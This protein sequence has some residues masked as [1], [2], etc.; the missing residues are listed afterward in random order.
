PRPQGGGAGVLASERALHHAR[1]GRLPLSRRPRAHRGVAGKVR[2]RSA[3]ARGGT[4][5]AGAGVRLRVHF[6]HGGAPGASRAPD[7]GRARAVAPILFTL[8]ELAAR[9]AVRAVVPTTP[10]EVS[11]REAHISGQSLP[12]F[13]VDRVC[14]LPRGFW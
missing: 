2:L 4:S 12:I 10:I 11:F 1:R 7:P 9:H 5:V 14:G 8:D 3:P 6:D 13:L